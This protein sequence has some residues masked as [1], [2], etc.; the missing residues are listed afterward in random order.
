MKQVKIN[1]RIYFAD[2]RPTTQDDNA[3][4]V[5]NRW[6]LYDD[7]A[8]GSSEVGRIVEW[9]GNILSAVVGTDKTQEVV[10]L[11]WEIRFRGW[12]NNWQ[13]H[14]ESEYAD[15]LAAAKDRV[16]ELY[17][18]TVRVDNNRYINNGLQCWVVDANNNVIYEPMWEIE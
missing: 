15:D 12:H 17:S 6:M 16:D 1:N 14:Y 4:G 3:G 2:E 10:F 7:L 13:E 8:D 5:L 18:M 11:P 9:P